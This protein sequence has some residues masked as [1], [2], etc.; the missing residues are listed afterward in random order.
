MRALLITLPLIVFVMAVEAEPKQF[1]TIRKRL[2]KRKLALFKSEDNTDAEASISTFSPVTS[3]GGSSFSEI[4]GYNIAQKVVMDWGAMEQYL[5][6]MEMN[7]ATRGLV[8]EM[9]DANPCVDSL[10]AYNAMMDGGANLLIDNAPILENL[11]TKMLSL[12]GERN[13]TMLMG[14]GASVMRDLDNV[15]PLFSYFMCQSSPQV[16]IDSLRDTALVLHKM[17]QVDSVPFLVFTTPIKDS[18]SWSAQLTEAVSG[19]LEH[20]FRNIEQHDCYTSQDG[21]GDFIQQL[22]YNMRDVAGIM[23]AMSYYETAKEI[24]DWATFVSSVKETLENREEYSF[25]GFCGLDTFSEIADIMEDMTSI[26]GEVG[27]G[28][29]A[30]QLGLSFRLDLLPQ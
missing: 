4:F 29:L 27:L 15:L 9:V 20:F 24:R 13:M 3:L 14:T 25:P 6:T 1:R 16:A 18:L 8:R 30:S 2:G 21:L 12:R 28:R 23:G 17:S 7:E 11:F 5:L 22:V 10:L 26:V 19:W